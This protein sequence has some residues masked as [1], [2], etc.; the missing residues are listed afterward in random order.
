MILIILRRETIIINHKQSE[1]T[2][3]RLR[4]SGNG[5]VAL[6]ATAIMLLSGLQAQA[7]T[8]TEWKKL[9][10]DVTL[11]MANDL[12]R[13][14]YYDQK[15]IAELMGNMAKTMGMECARRRRHPSL[16]RRGIS[17]R[18][19]VDHQLRAGLFASRTDARLVPRS[20]QS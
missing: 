3:K 15:P 18:P 2:M 14:G 11:Y 8:P 12:G 17:E 10:G 4:F 6:I 7:Q 9:K 13:N 20:W 1:R 16:Q 5:I 19:A